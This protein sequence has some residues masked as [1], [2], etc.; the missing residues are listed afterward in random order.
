M[1]QIV[2][3]FQ[4][5]DEFNHFY[6]AY[7]F[8]QG[9]IVV[10]DGKTD[11]DTGVL[12]FDQKFSHLPSRVENKVGNDILSSKN[13]WENQN[14]SVSFPNTAVY[15]PVVY[16]PQAL[17]I[18]IG[19]T[20]G[21]SVDST[22]Y[23][24]RMLSLLGCVLCLYAADR[25]YRTPAAAGLLFLMPM[26]VFQAATTGPDA[27]SFSISAVIAAFLCKA[28]YAEKP[29]ENRD[30]YILS[31]L[32]FILVTSRINL[33]PLALLPFL[34]AYRHKQKKWYILTLLNI[35]LI[36]VWIL[37]AMKVVGAASSFN[38]GMTS[39]EKLK[40]FLADPGR[41]LGY[42]WSTFT[43]KN[44]M[45]D[46]LFQYIGVL[47]WLDTALK[48]SF[49][50]F[51]LIFLPL[52]GLLAMNGNP[53]AFFKNINNSQT[54]LTM[55]VLLSGVL[56][57]FFI[58]LLAWTDIS[59]RNVIEGVQ[60]RYFIPIVIIGTYV[61]FAKIDTKPPIRKILTVLTVVFC[62]YSL[63]AGT[64]AVVKRYYMQDAAHAITK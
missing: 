33:T 46:Y 25:V 5:P 6:R 42:F 38:H 37:L 50:H 44:M 60:G 35:A 19:K 62:C 15:F 54:W 18:L 10:K 7:S 29:F 22:Y 57:T 40:V 14:A 34:I 24:A 48:K 12:A 39:G 63:S 27:L 31:A 47:G 8:S 64:T 59:K 3:A 56:L 2:P 1:L 55:S 51:V 21:L 16:T 32:I 20:A 30:F 26:V 13:H 41:L 9:E 53:K 61:L 4:A 58:L 17:A 11:I 23:L 45:K 43:D 28:F 49:Y 36:C 52:F